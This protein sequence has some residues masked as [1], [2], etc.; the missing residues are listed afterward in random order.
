M[1]KFYIE[2]YG[3]QMNKY[4]SEI[5]AG[6]LSKNG[7]LQVFRPEEA[8]ILLVNTCSVREHAE[9][10]ALG[11]AD[12][13]TVFKS[14]RPGAQI[15]VLGCMVQ[16]LG[17]K[18][19]KD[20]PVVDFVAAPD[21]YRKLP[22]ILKSTSSSA[23][24]DFSVRAF[25]DD[26]GSEELYDDVYPRRVEGISA[27]IAITRGCNN[28]CS[29]CIVPYVRGRERS[30][31]AQSVLN[32][33]HQLVSEGF[34]EVTLLGQNVNSYFDGK[35]DFPDLLAQVAEVEGLLRVR[36]ATSHP[37]DLS[38]K[39]VRTI[40]E[41]KKIGYH[42]H[43][44][45][46]SGSSRI[47][48]AMNRGYTREEYL[49][50]VELIRKIIPDAALTT[51]IIVGFPG[52]TEADFQ[53]TVSLVREVEYDSAFIFKYSPRP[54]TPAARLKETLTD[55]EKV[56]RLQELNAV[57]KEISLKK[58]RAHVGQVA[59]IL[60]EGPSRRSLK[61]A[62]GRMDNNKIVIVP[63]TELQPGTLISVRI[64]EVKGITLFG[65]LLGDRK[66][67]GTK[68]QKE[69]HLPVGERLPLVNE[70]D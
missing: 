68:N 45:V 33:V 48:K 2:T 25:L 69:K 67:S 63:N 36:F 16:N 41:H 37:K 44:P 31:S 64:T 4:D 40:A 14:R 38:E 50:R 62:M 11:R 10:R 35:T 51:D 47:L 65:E 32:E 12:N 5:V 61:D 39:L 13:L 26:S 46:Q 60:I 56:A 52:E 57:Q 3:C 49:K 1:K 15:G 23:K 70:L 6:I 8:D 22:E 21:S 27:W 9:K 43:L 55:E 17:E 66:I 19:L 20:H 30:R 54:H 18:I 42:I 58:N 28:F 7:Y 59:E 53:A 29:Y 34:L 24:E